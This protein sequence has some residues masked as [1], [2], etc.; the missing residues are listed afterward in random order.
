MQLFPLGISVLVLV[1]NVLIE[2]GVTN[3]LLGKEVI[4]GNVVNLGRLKIGGTSIDIGGAEYFHGQYSPQDGSDDLVL[5]HT[6]LAFTSGN[7]DNLFHSSGAR[8]QA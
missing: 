1:W 4:S 7:L 3:L 5:L 8:L 6:Q 2:V